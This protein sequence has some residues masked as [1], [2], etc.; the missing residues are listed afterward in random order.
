MTMES[1]DLCVIYQRFVKRARLRVLPFSCV[2]CPKSIT[3]RP[4]LSGF[5]RRCPTSPRMKST[6]HLPFKVH[7]ID[8]GFSFELQHAAHQLVLLAVVGT[9]LIWLDS[10]P[11]FVFKSRAELKILHDKHA[12]TDV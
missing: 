11:D 10:N 6:S 3:A 4:P 5:H 2:C 1:I 9:D 12:A 7:H 8:R